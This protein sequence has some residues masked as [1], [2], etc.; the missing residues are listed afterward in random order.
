V[1]IPDPRQIGHLLGVLSSRK[2]VA[3]L[4][5]GWPEEDILIPSSSIVPGNDARVSG[6]RSR[7]SDDP[8]R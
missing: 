4:C 1:T 7:S 2:L 3:Y 8:A 6:D 5:L